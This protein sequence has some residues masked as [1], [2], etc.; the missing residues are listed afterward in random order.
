ML[1][2]AELSSGAA[3]GVSSGAAGL[4]GLLAQAK[5]DFS[6]RAAKVCFKKIVFFSME[7]TS[8][9]EKKLKRSRM[10]NVWKTRT[11]LERGPRDVI[12]SA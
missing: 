5:E 4:L 12:N 9:K 7:K 1:A 10:R 2:K 11:R 3:A 8:R 6:A